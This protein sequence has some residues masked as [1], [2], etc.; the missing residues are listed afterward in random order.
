ME[1]NL[2]YKFAHV[3]INS[4]NAAEAADTVQRLA[5]MFGLP[6]FDVGSSVIVGGPIEIVKSA[7]RGRNGH[8]GIEV[9][10]MI[11][12]MQDLHQKGVELDDSSLQ[13][14]PDGTPVSI[15]LKQEIGGFA[16]HLLQSRH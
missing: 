4:E 13:I 10:D 6:S 14:S 9:S 2:T 15:Y 5:Q 11:L 7:A 1:P 8:I 3:G 12:A 16:F